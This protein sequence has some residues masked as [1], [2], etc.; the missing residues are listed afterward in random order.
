MSLVKDIF[1]ILFLMFFL[2]F[3]YSLAL[4]Y[5]LLQI[6]AKS[7]IVLLWLAA[8]HYFMKLIAKPLSAIPHVAW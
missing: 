4:Q 3:I 6:D 5:I 1:S 8:Q 2:P 7:A